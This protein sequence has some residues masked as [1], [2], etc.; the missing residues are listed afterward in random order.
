M[1]KLGR[2]F[3]ILLAVA[4]LA[5]PAFAINGTVAPGDDANDLA[6]GIQAGWNFDFICK[7]PPQ[8][9][10]G[11]DTTASIQILA[12]SGSCDK[13]FATMNFNVE[14]GG[15]AA[16]Y[17]YTLTVTCSSGN[18]AVAFGVCP[19]P[20]PCA[21]TNVMDGTFA[22]GN[23]GELEVTT[24]DGALQNPTGSPVSNAVPTYGEW[25]AILVG[26]GLLAGGAVL[27][28]RHTA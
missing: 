8:P 9:S 16:A 25:G 10:G 6:N 21:T 20:G 12:T 1:S 13:K 26:V 22:F 24:Y 7:R 4:A 2:F 11:S 18:I 5:G 15:F 19:S 3:L 27:I 17:G 28:F 23:N 14:T